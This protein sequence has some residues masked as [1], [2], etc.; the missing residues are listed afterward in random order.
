MSALATYFAG[1]SATL[2]AGF[3]SSIDDDGTK[4]SGTYTPDYTTGNFKKIVNGGAFT[5]G[6]PSPASNEAI[7]LTVMIVNGGSSGAVTTSGFT[8]VTGDTLTTTSTDE[9]LCYIDVFDIA[10]TEYSLLHVVALQ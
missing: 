10:A 7:S 3:N 8:K 1:K 6:P 4:S 9:F 2:T 5:L